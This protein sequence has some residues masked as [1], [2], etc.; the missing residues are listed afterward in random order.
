M[1]LAS[2]F[3]QVNLLL[4]LSRQQA[5][6]GPVSWY[7][8]P[9]TMQWKQHC[10]PNVL[11]GSFHSA[12][13]NMVWP[14]QGWEVLT[15][16]SCLSWNPEVS[17]HTPHDCSHMSDPRQDQKNPPYEPSPNYWFLWIMSKCDIFS[18]KLHTMW[19]N[20]M[21]VVLILCEMRE[22]FQRSWVTAVA[23]GVVRSPDEFGGL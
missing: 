21:V 18:F 19:V 12:S 15:M 9:N 7:G 2:C 6:S 20:T 1:V 17:S 8:V 3:Y 14:W 16:C 11:V 23:L 10:K 13:W 22:T 5:G 4:R